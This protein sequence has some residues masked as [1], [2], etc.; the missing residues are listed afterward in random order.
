MSTALL[1]ADFLKA[2]GITGLTDNLNVKAATELIF[3]D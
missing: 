1:K 2:A 3:F